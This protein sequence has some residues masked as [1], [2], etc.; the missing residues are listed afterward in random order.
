MTLPCTSNLHHVKT[1]QS[2]HSFVLLSGARSAQSKNLR[3]DLI[4]QDIATA[5]ILRLVSLAQE[6]RA[7]I[8]LHRHL[9]LSHVI[10]R[11]WLPPPY[12]FGCS[13]PVGEG[14]DPPLLSSKL[15]LLKNTEIVAFCVKYT[16][17]NLV[18]LGRVKPLPYRRTIISRRLLKK[19][20]CQEVKTLDRYATINSTK[21]GKT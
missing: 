1:A 19:I 14:L 6:D 11:R 3:T 18:G 21:F 2:A 12:S 9:P 20:P 8:W 13:T 5:Q 15:E 17:K 16:G 4:F 10:A 7:V